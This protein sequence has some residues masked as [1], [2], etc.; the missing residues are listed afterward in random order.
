MNLQGLLIAAIAFLCI[1]LFHPLVIWAEYHGSARVWPAFLAAGL[2]FLACSLVP[3]SVLASAALG[4]LG[5]SCL[6]SIRELKEQEERVRKGWFPRNPKRT[7]GDEE[8][9]HDSDH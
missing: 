9:G 8:A 1:G 4:V 2:L 3:E 6:W 5:C 7:Y